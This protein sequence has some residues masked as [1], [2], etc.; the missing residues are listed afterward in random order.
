MIAGVLTPSAPTA[1][2]PKRPCADST[3]PI[4]A[5]VTQLNP[6]DGALSAANRSPSA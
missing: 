3:E 6:Q 2:P 4:A 5:S 1:A